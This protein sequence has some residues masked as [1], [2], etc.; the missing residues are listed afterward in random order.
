MLPD[1]PLVKL[2]VQEVLSSVVRGLLLLDLLLL[3]LQP[4]LLLPLL[5]VL[6]PDVLLKRPLK[7]LP[8][9][10]NPLPVSK[11]ALAVHGV[12]AVLNLVLRNLKP[13]L[14]VL[15]ILATVR[16]RLELRSSSVGVLAPLPR[17]LPCLLRVLPPLLALLLL[18]PP[19]L[20]CRLGPLP[21]LPVQLHPALPLLAQQVLPLLLPP[22]D[23]EVHRPRLHYVVQQEAQ[24][25]HVGLV[26]N[27]L[28]LLG[29]EL[30]RGPLG[31]IIHVWLC[32]DVP[33]QHIRPCDGAPLAGHRVHPS[34]YPPQ[35]RGVLA[36]I[37][38]QDRQQVA[39]Q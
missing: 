31:C 15:A 29:P 12:S 13:Q 7:P 38:Q 20:L 21:P 10:L 23:L 37:Q 35:A 2:P 5:F 30:L 3:L 22:V 24:E 16:V 14:V 19:L 32:Q 1:G 6:L 36:A 18:P 4:R 11:H 8:L 9:L 33:R 28:V 34:P 39:V 25:L 27:L 17:G 26:L